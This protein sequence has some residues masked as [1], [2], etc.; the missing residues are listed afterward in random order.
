MARARKT[1]FIPSLSHSGRFSVIY[2]P[3][4]STNASMTQYPRH[5][6]LAT[7][8]ENKGKTQGKEAV[9]GGIAT[10]EAG[11]QHKGLSWKET[12]DRSPYSGPVSPARKLGLL[13]TGPSWNSPDPPV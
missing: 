6:T 4:D 11:E 12:M 8:K 10:T 3:S 9:S 13:A 1:V 5:F 2:K 7:L